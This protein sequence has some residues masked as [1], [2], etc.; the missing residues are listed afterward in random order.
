MALCVCS[1]VRKEERE[2][3]SAVMQSGW[4]QGD[5]SFHTFNVASQYGSFFHAKNPVGCLLWTLPCPPAHCISPT[6]QSQAAARRASSFSIA[7]GQWFSSAQHSVAAENLL[8]HLPVL[9]FLL[10]SWKPTHVARACWPSDTTDPFERQEVSS[11]AVHQDAQD[12]LK[13]D[14]CVL[15][16]E[17][18]PPRVGSRH[19]YF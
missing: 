4:G 17:S 2:D 14:R 9:L 3:W 5:T 16:I 13:E 1:V 11:L 18:G 10:Q 6:P 19:L 12:R 15:P 7:E 8:L